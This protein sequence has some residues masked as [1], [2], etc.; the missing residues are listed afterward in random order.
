MLS[1]SKRVLQEYEPLI[2]KMVK[3]F[4]ITAIAKVNYELLFDAKTLLSFAC[5]LPLLKVVQGL[6]KFAQ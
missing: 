5:V 6:S 1:P 3:D 2:M 4:T